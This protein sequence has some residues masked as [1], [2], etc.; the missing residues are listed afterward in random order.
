MNHAYTHTHTHTRTHAHTHTHHQ[1]TTLAELGSSHRVTLSAA[2]PS[3]RQIQTETHTRSVKP[4][5]RAFEI[6][7]HT[8][9]SISR[10]ALGTVRH[11]AGGNG[12]AWCGRLQTP[13]TQVEMQSSSQHCT[14][15]HR[16]ALHWLHRSLA[17]MIRLARPNESCLFGPVSSCETNIERAL[18]EQS[19]NRFAAAAR[20]RRNGNEHLQIKS[21]KAQ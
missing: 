2:L 1:I 16:T 15:L 10:C 5:C 21:L 6:S 13:T 14:A 9:D 11:G 19:N 18:L 20:R 12:A 8:K 4:H 17:H 7:E 3:K